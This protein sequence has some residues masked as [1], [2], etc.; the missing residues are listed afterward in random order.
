M[1]NTYY[2]PITNETYDM[3]GWSYDYSTRTYNV[4]YNEGDTVNI[5]YG[6]ENITIVEGGNTYNY[7]YYITNEAPDDPD[8]PGTSGLIE[9]F[10]SFKTWLG[11]KLDNIGGNVTNVT[12]IVGDPNADDTD[13]SGFLLDLVKTLFKGV[14]KIT[15][16]AVSIVVD[17]IDGLASQIDGFGDMFGLFNPENHNGV[18]YVAESPPGGV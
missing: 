15:T 10:E 9:W 14:V 5:T 13:G 7:Y 12:Q 16:H 11:E 8:N 2:S 18:Y 17:G 3:S 4:T 6:D 1:N